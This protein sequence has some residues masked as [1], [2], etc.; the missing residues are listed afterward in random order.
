MASADALVRTSK[1][2]G[3]ET[4]AYVGY[5]RYV[6]Q[7][8]LIVRVSLTLP[9]I[10]CLAGRIGASPHDIADSTLHDRPPPRAF[11]ALQLK[12]IAHSQGISYK[13]TVNTDPE[14][15]VGDGLAIAN[16]SEEGTL[17][18]TLLVVLVLVLALVLWL[19]DALGLM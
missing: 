3:E 4:G 1:N 15:Y 9:Q 17:M 2:P 5:P 14:S 11:S 12:L 18:L 10:R 19:V 16:D 7:P 6:C 13:M 8:A